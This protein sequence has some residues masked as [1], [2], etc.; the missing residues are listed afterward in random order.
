MSKEEVKELT[1]KV[2]R[3][4]LS[5]KVEICFKD[6]DIRTAHI[7]EVKAIGENKE[8]GRTSFSLTLQTTMQEQ[9]YTQGTFRVVLPDDREI[10][11]FMVPVGLDTEKRGMQYEVVYN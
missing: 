8:E 9:Y 5:D 4:W 6:D 2:F 3:E 1:I 7:E 10:V 11:M